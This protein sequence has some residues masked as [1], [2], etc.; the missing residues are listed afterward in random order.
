MDQLD[1]TGGAAGETD[2]QAGEIRLGEILVGA[3]PH[4]QR[5][6]SAGEGGD[7]ALL[8]FLQHRRRLVSRQQIHERA[9]V[10]RKDQRVAKAPDVE[11]RRDIEDALGIERERP[12]RRHGVT[13]RHQIACRCSAP[14]GKPVVPPVKNSAQRS[15]G[16]GRGRAEAGV[17]SSCSTVTP[18]GPSTMTFA[19][20]GELRELSCPIGKFG[21]ADNQARIDVAHQ[22]LDLAVG[23][24][25]I[26][27]R[28]LRAGGHAGI[29]PNRHL[30]AVAHQISDPLAGDAEFGE[31]PRQR[32]HGLLVLA[33]GQLAIETGQSLRIATMRGGISERMN[34][35]RKFRI[36]RVAAGRDHARHCT[37]L[38]RYRRV[39]NG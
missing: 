12:D 39:C 2:A 25:R 14:L 9:Q 34:D 1:R 31:C 24:S 3:E 32:R 21:V 26:E 15:S 23:I 5:R 13:E 10:D 18:S 38:S 17:D 8:K 6:R 22:R 7:A 37:F 20:A 16:S 27:R 11:Q 36:A 19:S 29:E 33:V 30:Q 4:I 35:G 28:H